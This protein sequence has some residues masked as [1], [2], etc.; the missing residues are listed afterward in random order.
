MRHRSRSS[1]LRVSAGGF[2]VAGLSVASAAAQT[3]DLGEARLAWVD[4]HVALVCE[5]LE[6]RGQLARAARCRE[7]ASRVAREARA[8]QDATGS[9]GIAPALASEMLDRPRC[10][11]V[12]CIRMFSS[13]GVGF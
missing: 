10:Q 11:G 3:S 13:L 2:L 9:I 12:A 7:E 5:P 4:R 8:G 6:A 1:F